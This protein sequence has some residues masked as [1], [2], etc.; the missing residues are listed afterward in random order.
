MADRSNS[1]I[2]ALTNCLDEWH[3]FRRSTVFYF[4]SKR[5]TTTVYFG[6][7]PVQGETICTCGAVRNKMPRVLFENSH[8]N[9]NLVGQFR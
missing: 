7:V 1:T 8:K 3:E 5:K 2:E 6:L 9:T 4:K